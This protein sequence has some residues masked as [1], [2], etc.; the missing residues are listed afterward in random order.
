M[1]EA[2]AIPETETAPIPVLVAITTTDV[3]AVT[4]EVGLVTAVD[5]RGR[6]LTV[7]RDVIAIVAADHHAATA[8]IAPTNVVALVSILTRKSLSRLLHRRSRNMERH[9]K[10][11]FENAKGRI[12]DLHF[13]SITR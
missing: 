3:H 4:P 11:F 8:Q 2:E 7:A 10:M 12:S 9:S 5:A 13:S 6:V 1:I